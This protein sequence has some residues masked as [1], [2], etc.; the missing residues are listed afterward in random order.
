[1]V[2]GAAATM[3]VC[4]GGDHAAATCRRALGSVP[5]VAATGARHW[6][7]LRATPRGLPD[8]TQRDACFQLSFRPHIGAVAAA[9]QFERSLGDPELGVDLKRSRMYCHRPRLLR[10]P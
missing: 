9:T 4:C 6:E 3:A 5:F 1:M 2:P 10:R 7:K 8:V